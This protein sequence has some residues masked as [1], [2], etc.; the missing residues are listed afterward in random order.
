MLIM[1][2]NK[3][4]KILKIENNQAKFSLDGINFTLIDKITKESIL[5]LINIVLDKDD[6]E[7]DEYNEALLANKAH[8]IIYRSIYGKLYELYGH[9]DTFRD[10]C[11]EMYKD[12]LSKYETD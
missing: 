6:I 7:M 2:G 4:M 1:K 5:S 10:D 11:S 12:A 9:K 8:Q 3:I